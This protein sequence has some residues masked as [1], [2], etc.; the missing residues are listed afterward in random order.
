MLVP[1]NVLGYVLS[2]EDQSDMP[3]QKLCGKDRLVF[4]QLKEVCTG[5]SFELY[6]ST[7]EKKASGPTVSTGYDV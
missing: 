7:L 4:N 5:S 6:L 1:K 2:K 3:L